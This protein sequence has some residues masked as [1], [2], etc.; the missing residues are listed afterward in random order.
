MDTNMEKGLL[1]T[2]KRLESIHVNND[3]GKVYK[4][5]DEEIVG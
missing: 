4:N 5:I 1:D 3:T 2:L